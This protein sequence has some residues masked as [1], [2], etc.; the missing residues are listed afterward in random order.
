MK[1]LR[2]FFVIVT[3][4]NAALFFF[5]D[6][7]QYI[8]YST[9]DEL[10]GF[11]D[12]GC[13]KKWD[14][15]T[16]AYPSTSF[17]EG[18]K[19]LRSLRLDTGSTLSKIE[20]VGHHLYAKFNRQAG[21]PQD[22]IH[23]SAPLDDYKILSGDTT[24]KVWCGTYAMMFA[25]FCW[26][27]NVVCRYVEIYKPGDHHVLN[28]CWVPELKSWVMVDITN[29]LLRA[30]GGNRILNTQDFVEALA[31]PDSLVVLSAGLMERKRFPGFEQNSGVT[32][33]YNAAFPFYYYHL[34]QAAIIYRPLEKIKRYILPVY[35]YE[36]FSSRPKGN[37]LF[38]TKPFF[39]V[40]WLL[41]G[42]LW[43]LRKYKND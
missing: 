42:C 37:L 29:N 9:Y 25:F 15:F 24:Q 20:A 13:V 16:L 12:E 36:I 30:E 3:V 40:L 6:S 41:L 43:Q 28:E 27:Q 26:S 10:Y 23:R 18:R 17:E 21:Y 39:A 1:K 8:K 11:C 31:K 32:N 34:T 22:V 35:W 5:K 33:Y 38:W 2:L 7:L 14:D 19:T 4:I